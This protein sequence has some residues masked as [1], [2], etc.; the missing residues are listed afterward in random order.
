[1]VVSSLDKECASGYFVN[2]FSRVFFVFLSFSFVMGGNDFEEYCFIGE[3]LALSSSLQLSLVI[4]KDPRKNCCR[5]LVLGAWYFV[6][7]IT[8]QTP[9]TPATSRTECEHVGERKQRSACKGI[10]D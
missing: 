9:P 7:C 2:V 3:N 10:P 4:P 1:M 8:L 6:I 5:C